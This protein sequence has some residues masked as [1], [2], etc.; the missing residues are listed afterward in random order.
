M[1]PGS[2]I[3]ALLEITL[4]SPWCPPYQPHLPLPFTKPS[5]LQG[6]HSSHAVS[7]CI[8]SLE[9]ASPICSSGHTGALS[10]GRNGAVCNWG[11]SWDSLAQ[12]LWLVLIK[13]LQSL[14]T[15]PFLSPSSEHLLRT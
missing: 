12:C 14:P 5:C 6:L 9:P 7:L 11:S 13:D 15:Y 4:Q 3:Q 10:E 8:L 1:L 2:Y